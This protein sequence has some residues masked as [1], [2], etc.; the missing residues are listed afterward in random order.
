MSSQWPLKSVRMLRDYYWE[1]LSFNQDE[2]AQLLQ[3]TGEEGTS[4]GERLGLGDRATVAEMLT[5]AEERLRYWHRRE[6]DF[7]PDDTRETIR[8]ARVLA[9]SYRRIVERVN[10]VKFYLYHL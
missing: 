5:C 2:V 6:N 10:K 7:R 4:L 1:K 9:H 8:A 3:V